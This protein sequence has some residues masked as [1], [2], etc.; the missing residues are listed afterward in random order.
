MRGYGKHAARTRRTVLQLEV[1]ES[2][3]LLSGAGA[4]PVLPNFPNLPSFGQLVSDLGKV[5]VDVAS[6]GVD[7][8]VLAGAAE[9]SPV[10]TAI[11]IARNADSFLEDIANHNFAQ[12]AIDGGGLLLT[13]V[14]S[15]INDADTLIQDGAQIV[16]DVQ[17]IFSPATKPPPPATTPSAPAPTQLPTAPPTPPQTQVKQDTDNDGDFDVVN[18]I[19]ID[20]S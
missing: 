3:T 13:K 18:G 19:V 9:G 15:V 14:G 2:R 20:Q 6:L 1:L 7:S 17:A 12:A 8:A 11:S 16:K 10:L 4:L 5:A